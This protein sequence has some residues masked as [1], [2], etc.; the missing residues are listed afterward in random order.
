MPVT[1]YLFTSE[2]VTE[3]HPDKMPT[4]SRD[5]V[6]DAMIARTHPPGGLRDAAQDRLRGA[7]RARS[8]PTLWSTI[9]RSCADGHKASATHAPMGFDGNTCAVLVGH[10]QAVARHRPAASI[11]VQGKEQGAGDQGMMFGYACDETPELM[12]APISWRTSS[13]AAWPR[14]ATR[15]RADFLRPDGKSQVTVRYEKG[16]PVARRRRRGLDPAPPDVARKTLEGSRDGGGHRKAVPAKLLASEHQVPH[17]PHRP[18]RDGRP[19]WATPASPAARSSSTPTAAWVATAAAPSPAR[20]PPR[21][22][23]APPT[24]RATSPRT[25][26]PPAWRAA[27]R[28]SWPTPS[29]WPSRCRVMVETFGTGTLPDDK[30]ARAVRQSSA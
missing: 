28:C 2:S 8:P 27:A 3:G 10:R 1:D 9:P 7:W 24:W 25:W 22:T 20:I 5:A 13:P 14:S 11:E 12:P 30:I 4:R 21:S 26:W 18:L 15:A 19:A 16:Q 6:L 29:A 23:A 17:Q